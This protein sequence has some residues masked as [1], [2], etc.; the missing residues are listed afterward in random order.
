LLPPAICSQPAKPS[1]RRLPRCVIWCRSPGI[2]ARAIPGTAAAYRPGSAGVNGI[3]G[4]R[5]SLQASLFPEALPTGGRVCFSASH[6]NLC[7]SV[8]SKDS[9]VYDREQ[10]PTP[11]MLKGPGVFPWRVPFCCS[12][13]PPRR[14]GGQPPGAPGVFKR[15]I[16]CPMAMGTDGLQRA[17]PQGAGSTTGHLSHALENRAAQPRPLPARGRTGLGPTGRPSAREATRRF[18]GRAFFGSSEECV[19]RFPGARSAFGTK[20]RLAGCPKK[21]QLRRGVF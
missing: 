19:G 8:R 3:R 10:L 11:R 17:K 16:R 20:T 13:R 7:P 14:P 5:P 1:A 6:K 9:R 15:S 4:Q 21:T 18:S 12:G 2:T